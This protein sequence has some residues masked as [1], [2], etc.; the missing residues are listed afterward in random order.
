MGGA[1]LSNCPYDIPALAAETPAGLLLLSYRAAGGC[2]IH[3]S[4]RVSINGLGRATGR[5]E[6]AA[7]VSRSPAESA[8]GSS[9]G[10]D[11][12]DNAGAGLAL[13]DREIVSALQSEPEA[14]AVAGV[15]A[16]L[17]RVSR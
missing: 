13:G 4:W 15:A 11:L 9:G 16:E 2:G 8:G 17:Q 7:V 5:G 12:F 3:T 14:A 10:F 6:R 1:L